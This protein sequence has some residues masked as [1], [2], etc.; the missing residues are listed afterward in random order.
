MAYASLSHNH[1]KAHERTMKLRSGRAYV[2]VF[3]EHGTWPIYA[4]ARPQE[5]VSLCLYV[6]SREY[7]WTRTARIVSRKNYAFPGMKL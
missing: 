1:A 6:H 7:A 3:A 5:H 2:R 4:C